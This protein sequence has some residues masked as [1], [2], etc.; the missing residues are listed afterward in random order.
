MKDKQGQPTTLDRLNQI[1]T[2][3]NWPDEDDDVFRWLTWTYNF[4]SARKEYHRKHTIKTAI[5]RR[6]AEQ[7]LS[8]D[9]L[10]AIDREAESRLEPGLDAIADEIVNMTPKE[11]QQQAAKLRKRQ[12]DLAD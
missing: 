8:K 5:L 1:L 4:L 12:H 2:D 11:V 10:E 7:L 6:M 9:E 3:G